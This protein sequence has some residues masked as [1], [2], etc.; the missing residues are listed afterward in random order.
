MSASPVD[1]V[2]ARRGSGWFSAMVLTAAAGTFA[3]TM[4]TRQTMGLFLGPLNSAT[5]L[6]LA[7]ISLAFAFGQLWWGLTQPFAGA[8]ADRLGAGRVLALGVALVALGTFLTPWMTSLPGL[9]FA[10]GVLAA[11]GAGMAGPAVLMAATMRHMPPSRRGLATGVVNAGGSFGQFVMAPIAGAL[12]LWLGWS[13]ALQLL[14]LLVLLAWPA[15]WV[16]RGAPPA[17]PAAAATAGRSVALPAGQALA[18]ALR[19]PSYLMLAVGFFVCGFH[20]AFLAT[21]LPGVIEGCGLPLQYGAWSLA[22]LGLFNIIGSIAMGWA[23]GRWR[24]KSLLSLV[25]A[26]RALAVLLFLLAPKTGGVILVFAAVMGLTFLSTVPPTAG[27]VA[28]FFGTG[29]MAMLFGSVMLSHQVGGF[30]GAWLG[31]RVFEAT[32]AYDWVWYVDIVLAIGAA[33]IHLPIREAPLARA[34][35]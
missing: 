33:L 9:I 34:S 35:A 4:G 6:G 26:T 14:G 32:G 28:K 19:H 21:H 24:M 15:A 25:Y 29:N 10:I 3:L 2:V 27:L 7:S 30:L 12:T 13:A 5:G 22:M 1:D 31:G 18:Q 23:V 16:L 8:L 11:G 17:A 20:V